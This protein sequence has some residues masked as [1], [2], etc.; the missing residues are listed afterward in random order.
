MSKKQ[1]FDFNITNYC[2]AKCPTCK[3]FDRNNYLELVPGLKLSH[4]KLEDFKHVL[5]K[6]R[7]PFSNQL[8]YF[9]G[10]FGD[11]L[12][13]PHITEFTQLASE[14][15]SEVV[16]YTNGGINRKDFFDYFSSPDKNVTVRF[17]IDG[18]TH[19]V[20][21]K[22]RIN[23]NT[24]LAYKN[25][26]MMASRKKTLWDFTIFEHNKHEIEDVIKLVNE[27]KNLFLM[28]RCNLRPSY[29]GVNRIQRSDYDEFC[30]IADKYSKSGKIQFDKFWIDCL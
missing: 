16:I 1:I 15:F 26:L 6:N 18:L 25:M 29:Y 28:I 21:N 27:H 11:P 24:E 17:G 14:I 9:C 19:E 7:S 13:H 5:D 30:R 2:N 3:R 20:N 23:V 12:M 4:M 8:C 22:Y 10:E